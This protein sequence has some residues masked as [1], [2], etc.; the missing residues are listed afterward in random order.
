MVVTVLARILGTVVSLYML[1]CTIRIFMTW[2]PNSSSGKV[3][4]YLAKIVDPYFALFSRF[5]S[6]RFGNMDFSPVLALV[7]LSVFNNIF[8]TLAYAGT[9][10]VGYVLSII[11][12]AVWSIVSFVL[13]LL[14]VCA[15][16][17]IVAYVA[18]MNSLQPIFRVIDSILNPALHAVNRFIYRDRAINYLQGLVTGLIVLLVLRVGG[19]A[20]IGWLSALLRSLPF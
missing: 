17:R 13:T 4:H 6:L 16:V 15:V 14:L 11:L 7:V 19:Q 3:S 12:S 20:L 1:L 9:I 2:I 18:H 10:T 5:R 8:T